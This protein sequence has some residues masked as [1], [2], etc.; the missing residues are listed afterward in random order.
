MNATFLQKIELRF[1]DIF[2][3]LLSE[4]QVL[5][6]TVKAVVTFSHDDHLIRQVALAGMIA[7]AGF[8]SGIFI[9]TLTRFVG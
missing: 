8:A 4:S 5:R 1:W 6:K 3:P 2:L 9:Y 7:C